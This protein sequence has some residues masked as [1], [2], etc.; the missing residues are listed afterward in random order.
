LISNSFSIFFSSKLFR[1]ETKSAQLSVGKAN[2]IKKTKN[3]SSQPLIE[4]T[5]L[6]KSKAHM[7]RSMGINGSAE[8][9][10][11]NSLEKSVDV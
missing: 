1:Y 10:M 8:T 11:L 7:S 4:L 9:E 3:S 6:G 5:S 2:K